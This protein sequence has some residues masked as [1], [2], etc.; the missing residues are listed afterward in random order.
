MLFCAISGKTSF[1][2]VPSACPCRDPYSGAAQ[3]G[4][5][6][7]A[8]KGRIWGTAQAG[9]VGLTGMQRQRQWAQMS[10][11]ET[12]DVVVTLAS[13]SPIYALGETDRVLFTDS[14]HASPPP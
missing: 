2:D 9:H 1:G 5:P 4:C 3:P 14:S 13:D 6:H 10:L 11:Y 12:G 8:G 7:C